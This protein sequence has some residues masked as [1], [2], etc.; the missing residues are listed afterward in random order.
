MALVVSLLRAHDI[1]RVVDIRSRP[2]SQWAHQFDKVRIEPTLH[3][4]E[5]AYSWR[6]ELLGQRPEGTEFYDEDGC[7]LYDRVVAR[8]GFSDE[9]DALKA[10]ANEQRTALFCLEEEPE[11]CHRYH[12]L[13]I[14]L[15]RDGFE[16]LHI[17]KTGR[18]ESQKDVFLRLGGE[19]RSLLDAPK[20]WRSPMPM[21]GGH[22]VAGKPT[23]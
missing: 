15:T 3:A 16:V 21:E 19:Q 9:Y 17:R 18:V 23:R 6:G 10:T 2:A 4:A 13:G 1:K 7:T 11:R 8:P 5:F 12:M 20:P 22:G 14:M